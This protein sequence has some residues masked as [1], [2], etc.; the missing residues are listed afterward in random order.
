M[1]RGGF[2]EPFFTEDKVDAD[3]WRLHYVDSLLR[4]DVL[5]FDNIQNLNAIRL[6]FEM[7]RERNRVSYF[8]FFHSRGCQ[9]LSKYSKEIHRDFRGSLHCF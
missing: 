5:E 4:T 3:R 8:F 7:L 9:H 1:E 2:P 6:V